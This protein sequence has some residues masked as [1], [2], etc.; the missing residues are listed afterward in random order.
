[1]PVY[2]DKKSGKWYY[3]FSY[4]TIAGET[5]RTALAKCRRWQG[6]RS[7]RLVGT[8]HLFRSSAMA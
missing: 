5:R 6:Y 3:E 4:K 8:Q 2:K 7:P 1:M